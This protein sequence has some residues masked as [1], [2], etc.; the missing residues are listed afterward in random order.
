MKKSMKRRVISCIVAAVMLISA[1]GC[2]NSVSAEVNGK[3]DSA[4]AQKEAPSQQELTENALGAEV[5]KDHLENDLMK[6]WTKP[7]AQD[8][9]DGLFSTYLSNSGEKLSADSSQ[10]PEEIKAAM[11]SDV[12]KDLMDIGTNYV[13]AHSRLTYAYGVAYH[14]TGNSEYL[15]MCRKGTLALQKAFDDQYGMYVK[16]D[17]ETGEWDADR[18]A[19]TSQDLAYGITGMGMYYFL[20]HDEDVLNSII[21]AKNYI[22][23]TYFDEN[24]GYITWLPKETEDM[25]TQIV[26]QLDQL[27]AYMLM[28]TPSL[29]EPYQTE[30]KNDMK[31]IAD[32][33]INRFYSQ[34]N[35][36][37]W[38]VVNDTDSM[39]LG[40]GHTDFGHSVKTLWVIMKVGQLTG[41][42]SYVD[43]AR[44]KI[45][46]ILKEAYIDKNGSWARRLNS[47]GTLDEDKEWWIFAELDQAAEIMSINDPSY[48][49][50]L[51]NTQKYWLETM[52]DHENGEI[53]HMV[54]ADGE[55]VISYPKAHCWKTSLHSFEHA[56]F[57]YMTA[58]QLKGTDFDLYYAF[59]E[60]ESV[61]E[62]SVEPYMFSAN[63]VNISKGE[64]LADMPKGNC[65][66][67]VTFNQ[68]Y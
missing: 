58:A 60:N 25:Q 27:Y 67:K 13:R 18:N 32:I 39:A 64:A 20:T 45:D 9:S 15:E 10:L 3:E 22:F 66:Y 51:N 48:Y 61:S 50:Y 8:M 46:N 49:E 63:A 16:K 34:K 5:W 23:D 29:P 41:E 57:G 68:L 37:F 35:G 42:T 6:F 19:R 12:M 26:A 14:M 65:V 44:P 31:K 2:S 62:N 11:E 59:P 36:L 47:D 21:K 17:K 4:A 56:L 43:F 28:L 7:D 52:V 38:G 55:P 24:K 40:S 1:V 54:S 53:W 33:L 30:W